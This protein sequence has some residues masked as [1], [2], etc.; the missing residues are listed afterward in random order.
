MPAGILGDA[1]SAQVEPSRLNMP[2]FLFC[3]NMFSQHLFTSIYIQV[4]AWKVTENQWSQNKPV[5]ENHTSMFWFQK[6]MTSGL[7]HTSCIVISCPMV[8]TSSHN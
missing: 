3:D 7:I 1:T 5:V 6:W 4:S 8:I 2:M